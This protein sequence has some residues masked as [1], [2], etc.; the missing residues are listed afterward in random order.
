LS[1][2]GGR[3]PARPFFEKPGYGVFATLENAPPGGHCRFLMA[4]R[5]DR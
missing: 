3:H 4:K 5:F 2:A 1:N